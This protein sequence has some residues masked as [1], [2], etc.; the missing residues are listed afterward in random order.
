MKDL[1]K[2]SLLN[3]HPLGRR[4][5]AEELVD[6]FLDS[7]RE[8]VAVVEAQDDLLGFRRHFH[9]VHHLERLLY[10]LLLLLGF[11]LI[12]VELDSK[13]ALKGQEL[14]HAEYE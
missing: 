3:E 1:G 14:K 6:V 11:H 12:H 13:V 10:V 4:K 9:V 2:D 5:H 7:L 8:E